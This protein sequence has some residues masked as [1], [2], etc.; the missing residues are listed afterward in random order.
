MLELFSKNRTNL[1]TVFK[2]FFKYDKREIK[3]RSKIDSIIKM[4]MYDMVKKDVDKKK[5][6][7]IEEKKEEEKVEEQT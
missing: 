1:S 3:V 5:Q 2:Q 4:G 7:N 6:N